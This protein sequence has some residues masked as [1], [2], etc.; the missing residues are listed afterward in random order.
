MADLTGYLAPEGFLAELQQELGSTMVACH[1]RLVLARGAARS[2]A[3]A[4]NVWN[5]PLEMPITSISDAAN[6]LRAIQRNWML[7]SAVHHRRAMLIAEKLPKVSAK[8][9]A[10]G[11]AAPSA[12]LGSWTLLS[13]DR[14]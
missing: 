5:E 3:W 13:S 10:F 8:P 1:G 2:V 6:K 7:Y 11:T 12:P 14:D 4:A 9:L